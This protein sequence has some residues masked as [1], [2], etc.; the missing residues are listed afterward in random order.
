MYE[1]REINN[2]VASEMA[3]LDTMEQPSDDVLEIEFR[4]D[5]DRQIKQYASLNQFAKNQLDHLTNTLRE[6]KKVLSECEDVYAALKEKERELAQEAYVQTYPDQLRRQQAE[7]DVQ[8]KQ[9]THDL[10][11]FLDEYYPPH[12]VDVSACPC[13][14][15]EWITNMLYYDRM[16]V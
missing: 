2:L 12:A 4:E 3:H 16:Q 14:S 9:D 1:H 8:Y 5:V 10:I 13:T 7:W 6:E 11:D 15:C